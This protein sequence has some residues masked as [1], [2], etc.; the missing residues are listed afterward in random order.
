MANRFASSRRSGRVFVVLAALV[1]VAGLS[2]LLIRRSTEPGTGMPAGETTIA[3]LD[4]GQALAVA[5]VTADGHSLLFDA[6]NSADDAEQAVLPFLREHGV[7]RLDYLVL[8]HPHQD[9]VGG[10]PAVLDALPVG[11]FVDP[12]IPTT[13][14]TYRRT[15]ELV[16]QQGIQPLRARRGDTLDLGTATAEIL[17]PGDSPIID[18]SGEMDPNS[19]GTVLR[20]IT[21]NVAVLL[22]GDLEAPGEAA[23]VAAGVDDLRADVLQVGHHGSRT[24]STPTFLDAVRPQVGIISVGAGNSYGHPHNEVVRR[25]RD[26]GVET[27]RT[28]VDGTIQVVT[29]GS[30]YEI[31][32]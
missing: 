21:G 16:D 4:V 9:H 12:V 5:V 27:Y 22:T 29:D 30:D 19:N 8:S 31:R 23:L 32:K 14:Q 6:G 24:S 2:T 1:L 7:D 20:V 15:L 13:N 3:F 10:M 28:D 11:T 18:G 17:W 25:L 26:N